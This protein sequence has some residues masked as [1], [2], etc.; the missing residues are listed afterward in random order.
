MLVRGISSSEIKS[1]TTEHIVP[2]SSRQHSRRK[3]QMQRRNITLQNNECLTPISAKNYKLSRLQSKFLIEN[4][5][6]VAV[7][8]MLTMSVSKQVEVKQSRYRP[9]V[10]QRIPGS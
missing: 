5:P 4:K 9:G 1:C 7:H 8:L 3:H 6:E 2:D 10:A